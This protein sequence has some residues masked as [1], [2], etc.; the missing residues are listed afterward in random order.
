MLLNLRKPPNGLDGVQ[1]KP[2]GDAQK[3]SGRP[4]LC[5]SPRHSQ[6]NTDDYTHLDVVDSLFQK[7]AQSAMQR[8]ARAGISEDEIEQ[9]R[10]R[11]LLSLMVPEEYGG[12]GATWV[13]ALSIVRALAQADGLIGQAYGNHLNLTVLSHSSGTPEQKEKYYRETARN[14]WFWANAID[15]WDTGVSIRPEGDRFRLNGVKRFD[16]VAVEADLW[17]LSAWQ[18]GVNEPLFCIIPK[19]RPGIVS[20]Q[21]W[22]GVGQNPTANHSLTL[23]NVLVEKDEILGSPNV[24]NHAFATISGIIAQLTKIHVALGIGQGALEAVQEYRT[25]GGQTRLA[26]IADETTSNSYGL[27]HS[28]DLRLELQTAIR[29]ADQVTA[30]VQAA[31]EKDFTLAYEERTEVA[32]AVFVAEAFATRV[33]LEITNHLFSFRKNSPSATNGDLEG[34]WR[35]LRIFGGV[36]MPWQGVPQTWRLTNF[37]QQA[38]C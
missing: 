25:K 18:D 8:D 21:A 36:S 14:H 37:R 27:I 20:S 5:V 28:E 10:E 2:V 16:T 33:G 11:G 1:S 26:A 19:D 17:V 9:L 31:W 38:P 29:L 34:Y 23:D 7:L 15:I 4:H 6:P 30:I 32:N 3:I 35:D 12:G 13:E 24:A 22:D